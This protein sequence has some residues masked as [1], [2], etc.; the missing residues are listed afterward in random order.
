[1]HAAFV[2]E[3]VASKQVAF[4]DR[5]VVVWKGGRGN[6]EVGAQH[7]HQCLS[8]GADIA[9]GSAVKSR[10]VFEINLLSPLRLQPA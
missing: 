6:A 3:R 5:P 9:L 2:Q 1:M 4:E 7:V 10:A 8:N